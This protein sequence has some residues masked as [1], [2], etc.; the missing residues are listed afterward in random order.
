MII[1]Y[2]VPG[3][4]DYEEFNNEIT[5]VLEEQPFI[6]YSDDSIFPTRGL[7]PEVDAIRDKKLNETT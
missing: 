3:Y 7:I 2:S 6:D 5:E 4:A 1:V